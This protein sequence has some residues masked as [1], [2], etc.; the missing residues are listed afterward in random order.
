MTAVDCRD[1]GRRTPPRQSRD[2]DARR[3][4]RQLVGVV[5]LSRLR[6]L[7][8]AAS[9]RGLPH[10]CRDDSAMSIDWPYWTQDFNRV[11]K[12]AIVDIEG[13]DLTTLKIV[14][15]TYFVYP[16]SASQQRSHMQSH[17]ASKSLKIRRLNLRK[18]RLAVLPFTER[19]LL[20]L[21]GH[22][23]NEINVLQK[24]IMMTIMALPTNRPIVD[25]VQ[26]GQAI[27]IMRI[28]IGKLHEAWDLFTAHFQKDRG[29]ATKYR[30]RLEPEATAALEYLR[31]H[32]GKGSPLTRIRNKL[33]FHYKDEGD[34][35]ENNFNNLSATEP[36]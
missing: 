25:H 27:I 12:V 3:G 20:L 4:S 26:T 21:L 33:A 32:F 7:W 31:K 2:G 24:L 8:A 9:E 16:D 23:S 13:H 11:P 10:V 5:L 22:A 6:A 14:S 36:W 29:I 1:Y 15:L 35:I 17:L 28:L 30:P 34:L 19:R 18:D